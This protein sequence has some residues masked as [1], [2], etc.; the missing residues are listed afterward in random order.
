MGSASLVMEKGSRNKP[1]TKSQKE[2]NKAMSQESWVVEQI[3]GALA[4]WFH[5]Q[6]IRFKGLE[7]VHHQ[8][9]L[10]SMAYH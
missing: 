10:E 9:V 6:V 8:H 5:G 2:Q 4:R 7:K 1:L 3:F